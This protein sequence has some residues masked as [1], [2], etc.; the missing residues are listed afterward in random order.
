MTGEI[1]IMNE[2]KRCGGRNASL[3]ICQDGDLW[4][5]TADM[6]GLRAQI[7]GEDLEDVCRRILDCVKMVM[8]ST[9]LGEIDR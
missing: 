9:P 2:I 4:S 3:T 5:C 8:S 7:A 1:W 6:D